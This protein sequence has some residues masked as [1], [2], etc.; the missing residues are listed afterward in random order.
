MEGYNME[1][2]KTKIKIAAEV[3]NMTPEQVEELQL[4]LRT[5][6]SEGY[7]YVYIEMKKAQFFRFSNLV[8][9]K[10]VNLNRKE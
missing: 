8:E 9:G 5:V 2:S 1:N 6:L 10:P 4:R 3:L 7:G